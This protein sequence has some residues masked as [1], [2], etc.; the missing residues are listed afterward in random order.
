[1]WWCVF[2]YVLVSLGKR[3]KT[4]IRSVKNGAVHHENK[5]R[6]KKK[7]VKKKTKKRTRVITV[8]VGRSWVRSVSVS[9]NEKLRR[10]G[11]R[12]H[13]VLVYHS[14]SFKLSPL[15]TCKRKPQRCC[16]PH[17]Y[18]HKNTNISSMPVSD[19]TTFT[20]SLSLSLFN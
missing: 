20:F 6:M 3:E 17:C 19:K 2:V 10:N 8:R 1:M 15:C 11:S 12:S 16:H 13:H 7:R 14:L 9:G 5:Q 18:T 4:H